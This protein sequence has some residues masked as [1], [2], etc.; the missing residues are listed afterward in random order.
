MRRYALG[1]AFVLTLLIFGVLGRPTA[2]S[3]R[4]PCPGRYDPVPATEAPQQLVDVNRN[5]QVCQAPTKDI[6]PYWK[7]DLIVKKH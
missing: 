7:D 6:Q 4:N 2:A 5:G 1:T 3:G